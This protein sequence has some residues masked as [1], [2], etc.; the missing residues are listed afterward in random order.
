GP[1]ESRVR[2]P[3]ED[4]SQSGC[5]PVRTKRA[6]Q[7]LTHNG[8]GAAL[9]EHELRQRRRLMNALPDP[10][11]RQCEDGSGQLLR[12]HDRPLA[13]VVARPCWSL[14]GDELDVREHSLAIECLP[15]IHPALP[16]NTDRAVVVEMP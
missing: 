1:R 5:L 14:P 9:I 11:A 13:L 12:Q 8:D 15:D 3:N 2:V 7:E 10:N 4:S 6:A 16:L